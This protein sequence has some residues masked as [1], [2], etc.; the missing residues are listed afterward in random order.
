VPLA[1]PWYA[2][3]ALYSPV[4]SEV[5]NH[6]KREA[7]M[8]LAIPM[9]LVE[10]EGPVGTVLEHGVR[11]QVR[12]DL[13]EEPQQGQYLLIHAG[14]AIEVLDEDE[15]RETLDLIKQAYPT[16]YGAESLDP[17]AD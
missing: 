2:H 14:Y 12:L 1:V 10:V 16:I 15:A 11:R 17:S 13:I 9:K 7:T 5:A 6:F 8:C 4:T 3:C